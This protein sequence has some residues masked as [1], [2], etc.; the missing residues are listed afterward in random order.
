MGSVSEENLPLLEG[1]KINNRHG[2]MYAQTKPVNGP[3]TA[4]ALSQLGK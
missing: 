3:E 4:S 2:F 1:K